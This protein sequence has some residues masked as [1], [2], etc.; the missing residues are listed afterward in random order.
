M[1]TYISDSDSEKAII[2]GEIALRFLFFFHRSS[3]LVSDEDDTMSFWVECSREFASRNSNQM[4]EFC[5][6]DIAFCSM[7]VWMK[8]GVSIIDAIEWHGLRIIFTGTR[9]R[10]TPFSWQLPLAW[11]LLSYPHGANDKLSARDHLNALHELGRVLTS[12]PAPWTSRADHSSGY[13]EYWILKQEHEKPN[14]DKPL[15]NLSPDGSF[16][17]FAIGAVFLE[18][19]PKKASEIIEALTDRFDTFLRKYVTIYSARF[20]RTKNIDVDGA[21]GSSNFSDRQIEL[22]QRWAL[23]QID[24]V[25]AKRRKRGTTVVSQDVM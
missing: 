20:G 11:L 19:N 23:R 4:R 12:T 15:P 10:A 7:F 2:A 18:E 21:I 1:G 6:R 24:F 22:V 5:K 9:H 3:S 16:A 14:S 13:F 8:S 17:L 25:K